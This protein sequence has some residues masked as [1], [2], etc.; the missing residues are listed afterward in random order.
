MSKSP[1]IVGAQAFIEQ[2]EWSVREAIV[3]RV[4]KNGNFCLDN[5]SQQYRPYEQY[6]NGDTKQWQAMCAGKNNYSRTFIRLADDETRAMYAERE[7]AKAR[8]SRAYELQK[9]IHQMSAQHFTDAQLDAI[10]EALNKE[11]I[12]LFHRDR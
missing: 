7:K 3:T 9:R 2:G 8:R 4:H 10:E 6:G 1:F 5:D 12:V 11:A